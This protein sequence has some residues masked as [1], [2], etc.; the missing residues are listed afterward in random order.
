VPC[1]SDRVPTVPRVLAA[2][3]LTNLL[4]PF[5]QLVIGALVLLMVVVAGARLL[6][7]GPSRMTTAMVVTGAAAVGL[8]TLGI[9]L[10]GR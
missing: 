4:L 6:R 7:R 3:A 5:W 2:E 10:Q 9:L 1:D 8:A